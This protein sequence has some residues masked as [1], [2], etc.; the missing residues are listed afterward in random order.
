MV[1][2][3]TPYNR[4]PERRKKRPPRTTHRKWSDK[5]VTEDRKLHATLSADE[6]SATSTP[7]AVL[8]SGY[9]ITRDLSDLSGSYLNGNTAP[10]RT[11]IEDGQSDTSH[12]RAWRLA[13]IC[14]K[15]PQHPQPNPDCNDSVGVKNVSLLDSSSSSG[16]SRVASS[17]SIPVN[18]L[19]MDPGRKLYE[20]YCVHIDIRST[21]VREV[22]K[23]SQDALSSAWRTDYDGVFSIRDHHFSQLIHILNLDKY[24]V[25]AHEI[26]VM[27]PWSMAAKETVQYA[28]TLLHHLKQIGCVREHDEAWLLSKE[29]QAR[30]VTSHGFLIFSPPFDESAP[31]PGLVRVDVLGQGDESSRLTDSHC[32]GASS[33]L[34][35]VH[36][37]AYSMAS[38]DKEERQKQVQH[39]EVEQVPPPRVSLKAPSPAKKKPGFWSKLS[40]NQRKKDVEPPQ[41]LHFELPHVPDETVIA[42]SSSVDDAPALTDWRGVQDQA[43]VG[44]SI[45]SESFPLLSVGTRKLGK[46]K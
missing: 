8:V 12:Q 11:P 31:T 23:I 38:Q 32:G 28:S 40:C 14:S 34:S 20:L 2:S 30:R 42:E 44:T 26:L 9:P 18:V 45:V 27:K 7:S 4:T 35:D 17:D 5:L 6:Q 19:L 15:A 13:G 37:H 43:S 46:K 21:T 33:R 39:A 1:E 16:T 29:A 22:I 3:P 25:Q 10:R 41:Q 24:H 36:M